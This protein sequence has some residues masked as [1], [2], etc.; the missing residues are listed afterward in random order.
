[1]PS[2]TAD[3]VRVAIVCPP[4]VVPVMQA[5]VPAILA[6]RIVCLTPVSADAEER[7]PLFKNQGARRGKRRYNYAVSGA[8][9]PVSGVD[10]VRVASA[11]W[12]CLRPSQ[13]LRTHQPAPSGTATQEIPASPK[14]S[15]RING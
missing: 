10:S 11:S 14:P 4:L 7:N 13:M 5:I 3:P 15:Q 6:D 8:A 2:H 9:A 12:R 1:V